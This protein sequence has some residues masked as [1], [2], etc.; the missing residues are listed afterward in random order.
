LEELKAKATEAQREVSEM[1]QRI[2]AQESAIF[3]K[4]AR[5]VKVDNIA[6]YEEER[7]KTIQQSLERG[8]KLASQVPLNPTPYQPSHLIQLRITHERIGVTIG[9]SNII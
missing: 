9:S 5:E 4:F 1:E 6:Q 7:L 2:R 8:T 3:E